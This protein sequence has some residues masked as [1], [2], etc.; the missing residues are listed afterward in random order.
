M[1]ETIDQYQLRIRNRDIEDLRTILKQPYGRRFVWRW[2]ERAGVFHQSFIQGEPDSTAFNEGR[3]SLGNALL[4][5][6][7]EIRPE[8]YMEM[9]KMKQEDDNVRRTIEEQNNTEGSE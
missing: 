2:L 7:L 8:S 5:E 3:R 9:M 4:S 6:V 1:S